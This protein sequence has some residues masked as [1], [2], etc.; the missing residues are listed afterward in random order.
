[1]RP[2]DQQPTVLVIDDDAIVRLMATEALSDA[3][4]DVVE[5]ADAESGWEIFDRS[6]ADLVLLDVILPGMNGFEACARL[7]AHAAGANVPIIVMTGL[8]DRQSIASAYDAGATDFITKPIVWDL[9][10][11][12]VR[13]ALRASDAF[14]ETLRSRTLLSRSQSLANMGSWEWHRADGSL[15][16]SEEMN[17]IVG[18]RLGQV[19]AP[20]LATLL[21]HVH[22]DDRMLVERA[23]DGVM[24]HG[25]A[26][27]IEF[28]IVRADG[29]VRRL[30][31]QTHIDRV[32]DAGVSVVHGVRRDI[33]EQTEANE[34]I[35]SLAFFDPLTGLANRSLF[36]NMV[37][38]MLSQG[39]GRAARCAVL[40]VD[41]DRFKLIN[42]SYG[43][44]VG[45]EVLK[46]VGHRLRD[47][48]RAADLKGS[49]RKLPA[50]ESVARLGGDEFTVLLGD[51]DDPRQAN[52]VAQ[53]IVRALGETIV[54]DGH[55]L[56]VSASIGISMSPEDGEDTDSLLTS[57]STAMHAA[58]QDLQ[59]RVRFY[60][61]AMS[62]AIS[63]KLMI[64]TE[65]RRALP[66]PLH[67]GE[68]RVYYQAKVDLRSLQVV[69]AEA[70]IRW[71]HP[72]R[73]LVEPQE[74]IPIAEE[75]GLIVPITQWVIKEVCRQLAAWEAQGR[76]LIPVSINLDASSLQSAD[77][78]RSAAAALAI[79]GLHASAIEF[80]VTE[81]GLMR[82]LDQASRT[83]GAL[84]DIGVTLSID[85]FGTGYSSLTYL[86]RFPVDILKIDRSFI[87]ELP[88][89][90]NDSA[91]ATAIIAMGH[92]LNL[93]L[94]AE[95]V[96]TWEQVDFLIERRCFVAQGY[97]FSK[98]LPAD[99]F[100]ALA[101]SKPLLRRL[102]NPSTAK[103]G[104]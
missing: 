77:L 99:E 4:Y 60:D 64:E 36:R 102:A 7:R 80:E 95:G 61:N 93:E 13:Y 98:P 69:G 1:M 46:T 100:A 57:A 85:D 42:E 88:F 3:G 67:Q 51:I 84:R 63:H 44:Q 97:L 15:A 71:I 82:D 86:K 22:A 104:P 58:K 28:R 25:L 65:L 92:S 10:P 24:K 33:T 45:D 14:Q 56:S 47:C 89:D 41:I 2:R 39:A 27:S 79:G 74:F 35:R 43:P 91:L 48:L 101:E 5:A 32:D 30:L 94:I 72:V 54:V 50:E 40:I 49:T 6:G 55:E 31:E 68:L 83:L 26:Y 62:A 23:L 38:H 66:L 20:A 81:S 34:R 17:R 21:A 37:Q 87:K 70:L 9:L 53:R 52:L 11:Y 29:A 19:D 76:R 59:H 16:W 96:E 12:R 8:D 78:V 75:S 73:G 90:S 103:A 18:T